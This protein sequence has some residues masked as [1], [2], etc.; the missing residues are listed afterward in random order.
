MIGRPMGL[1][2]LLGG[3]HFFYSVSVFITVGT[4]PVS[5]FSLTLVLALDL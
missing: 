4:A 1:R 3:V 2:H 5:P